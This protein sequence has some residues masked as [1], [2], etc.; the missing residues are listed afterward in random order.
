M[1]AK[2]RSNFTVSFSDINLESL[3]PFILA[4]DIG[5]ETFTAHGSSDHRTSTL[6]LWIADDENNRAIR[7]IRKH[8]DS[9]NP[10]FEVSVTIHDSAGAPKDMFTFSNAILHAMQHS[11]FTRESQDEPIEIL[12]YRGANIQH[13]GTLKPPASRLASA[14]LL[15][16]AF[17]KMTHHLI[18]G[19]IQ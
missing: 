9:L 8:L 3:R 15:Q 2:Q 13:R 19:N 10:E 6:I 5:T 14:K 17:S 1:I 18:D 7:A 11:I 16:I 4:A 12:D